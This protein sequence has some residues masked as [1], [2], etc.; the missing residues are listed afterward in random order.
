MFCEGRATCSPSY[1][2]YL[3]RSSHYTQQGKKDVLNRAGGTLSIT[4]SLTSL[5]VLSHSRCEILRRLMGCN[6]RLI[7]PPRFV[8]IWWRPHQGSRF[9]SETACTCAHV[10]AIVSISAVCKCLCVISPCWSAYRLYSS[11]VVGVH[12]LQQCSGGHTNF[13]A[14][15]WSAYTL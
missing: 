15:P 11:A 7:N 1:S 5:A 10:H 9:I 4:S 6:F 8:M 14:V 12:I 3:Q 13:T 2:H